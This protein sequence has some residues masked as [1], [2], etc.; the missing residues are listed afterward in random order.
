MKS[1]VASGAQSE[2]LERDTS[3]MGTSHT[4]LVTVVIPAYN[5]ARFVGEA[6]ESVLRQTVND[7]EMIVVDDGSTDGTADVVQHCKDHR[8]RFLRQPHAGAHAALNRGISEAKG[9]WIAFL[10]SDD[11]FLPHKLER[12][13]HVHDQHPGLESSASRVRYIDESG[14]PFAKYSYYA[15]RYRSMKR[16]S[17]QASSLFSSLLAANHLIST[18]SLFAK[19]SVLM[20]T[21]GF[22]A[23]RYVHDWFM[24]LSLASRQTFTVIEE[25]LTDY[26]RHGGNTIREDDAAGQIE[27][28]MALAWQ[29]SA[30]L[31]QQPASMDALRD[32]FTALKQNSRV[33]FELFSLFGLWRVYSA[34]G[35]M[36]AFDRLEGQDAWMLDY[37]VRQL[38]KKRVRRAMRKKKKKIALMGEMGM[39]MVGLRHNV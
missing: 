6:V 31:E 26:R 23:L 22:V 32:V 16:Q 3:H 30:Y 8:L 37:C 4:P 33:D 15:A 38:R 5:H 39:E 18:S 36:G 13:L 29:V 7:W 35:H 19:R 24:F 17:S 21:G 2:S 25:E 9:V 14:E 28:N 20:D 1:I 10:N 27:D 34:Q 12:H 11:R